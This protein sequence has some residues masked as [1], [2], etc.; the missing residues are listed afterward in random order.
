MTE[1]NVQYADATDFGHIEDRESG[2]ELNV[3]FQH[4]P[5]GENGINGVQNEELLDLLIMRIRILQLRFP[6]PENLTALDHLKFAV[7]ELR[8]RTQRRREQGVEGKNEPHVS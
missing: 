2:V 7:S 1:W 4:G 5:I 3:Q 6:C 8:M